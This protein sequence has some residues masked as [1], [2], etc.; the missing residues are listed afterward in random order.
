MT[1]GILSIPTVIILVWILAL[2]GVATSSNGLS[3]SKSHDNSPSTTQKVADMPVQTNRER[4]FRA[5]FDYA[6]STQSAKRGKKLDQRRLKQLASQMAAK[7]QEDLDWQQGWIEGYTRGLDKS[8]GSNHN[9]VPP[10][11]SESRATAKKTVQQFEPRAMV[12]FVAHVGVLLPQRIGS[13]G[14]R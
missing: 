8:I 14:L 9:T 2:I 13:K 7:G 12:T 3:G 1:L 6:V 11:R 5:G 4:G 10:N